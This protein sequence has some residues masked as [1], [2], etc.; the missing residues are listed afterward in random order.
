M[1][2]IPKN[3]KDYL[4]D[5]TMEELAYN[6]YRMGDFY[7]RRKVFIYFDIENEIWAELW[8]R[9]WKIKKIEENNG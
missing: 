3:T 6:S 1:I 7:I 9:T 5:L 8:N 2:K 4:I